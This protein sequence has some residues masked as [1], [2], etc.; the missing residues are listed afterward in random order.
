MSPGPPP[1]PQ[2]GT[3]IPCT[4]R[5]RV[6]RVQRDGVAQSATPARPSRRPRHLASSGR[7]EVPGWGTEV[8][9]TQRCCLHHPLCSDSKNNQETH[10]KGNTRPSLINIQDGRDGP[11]R[12]LTKGTQRQKRVQ[13]W[14]QLP[15][16]GI[17]FC[18]ETTTNRCKGA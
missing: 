2:P 10:A 18:Q 3:R 6:L 7:T 1:S 4:N 17:L 5:A 14:G 9:G 15:Q 8:R 13:L 11:A 16:D 12:G